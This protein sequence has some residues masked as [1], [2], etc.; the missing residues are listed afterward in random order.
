MKRTKQETQRE[1]L[2]QLQGEVYTIW[3]QLEAFGFL[4]ELQG[5]ECEGA[6]ELEGLGLALNE[7]SERLCDVWKGLDVTELPPD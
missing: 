6:V 3:K 4:L 1:R 5:R 2:G 7:T